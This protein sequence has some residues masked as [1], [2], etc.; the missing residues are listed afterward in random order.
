M[1]ASSSSSANPIAD[2]RPRGEHQ[3]RDLIARR[4]KAAADL[5]A[6]DSGKTEVEDHG[7]VRVGHGELEAR[8]TLA[9][10]VGLV[11]GSTQSA[12]DGV[13]NGGLV[14]DQKDTHLLRV[15]ERPS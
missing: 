14:F 8:G 2:R 1:R 10:K 9:G 3:H 11:P 4:P 6:I 5:D 7:V 15:Y 12:L 13:S